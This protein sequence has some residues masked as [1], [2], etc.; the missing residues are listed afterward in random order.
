MLK[1]LRRYG[2]IGNAIA[3][4]IHLITSNWVLA[5]SIVAGVA[6]SWWAYATQWGYLPIFL[7]GLVAF[8]AFVWISN[9]V[10]YF[11]TR[12]R[13]SKSKMTFD[14]SFGFALDEISPSHDPDNIDNSLEFRFLIRNVAPGPLK[15]KIERINAIIGDRIRATRNGEGI[16]PRNSSTMLRVG[17]FQKDQVDQLPNRISGIYEISIIYGHP[18]DGYSRRCSKRIHFD[19]IRKD[20]SCFSGSMGYFR[21]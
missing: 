16:L 15:Y 11:T 7:F 5:M 9:G 2:V 1:W 20:R 10:V 17:G 4:T 3:A 13:P 14:Y 21:R 19:L 18:D 8:G 6:T 12:N